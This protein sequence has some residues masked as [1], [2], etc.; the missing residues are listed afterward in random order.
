MMNN[1]RNNH[2][3]RSRA[4]SRSVG[5]LGLLLLALLLP[6]A[7]TAQTP[8]KRI[9]P[10]NPDAGTLQMIAQHV[11]TGCKPGVGNL[12]GEI[13]PLG[14]T[15]LG[16]HVWLLERVRCDTSIEE[17]GYPTQPK[18]F[19]LC[20]TDSTGVIPPIER[21]VRMVTSDVATELR[22]LCAADFD[23]NG[24]Q[25]VVCQVHRINDTSNGNVKGYRICAVAVFWANDLGEYAED[26]TTQISNGAQ[27]WL[28]PSYG[29]GGDI[30][31]DGCEDGL[32]MFT[33]SGYRD[34]K[35]YGGLPVAYLLRGATKRWKGSEQSIA[36]VQPWWYMAKGVDITTMSLLDADCDGWKDL[37]FYGGGTAGSISICYGRP[38]AF[39]DTNNIQTLTI[40]QE[41]GW[42]ALLSDVTGDGVPELL[43]KSR[44]SITDRILLFAG[45]PRQRL[46][47]QYGS[48]NDSLD[49]AQGRFPT[50]PWA[51]VILPS[52]LHDGWFKSSGV[53]NLGDVSGDG[54]DE[55]WTNSYPFLI[56]YVS[57]GKL[58]SLA[59]VVW[60]DNDPWEHLRLG[61][62]DPSGIAVFAAGYQGRVLYTKPVMVPET[63]GSEY[64]LPHEVGYRCQHATTAVASPATQDQHQWQLQV[65]PQPAH[66]HATI[67]WNTE[68]TADTLYLTIHDILGRQV[69]Q[70]TIPQGQSSI[71]WNTANLV[72]G[73][74]TITLANSQ[75][76]TTITTLIQQH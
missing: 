41:L 75:H 42:P 15:P 43:V 38:N 52:L 68:Q 16:E 63:W 20:R 25:D 22:F 59:D 29:I 21:L 64:R 71:E 31:N 58:D 76:A 45:K 13:H 19:L 40:P 34:G 62:L 39:P 61:T 5:L 35:P 49:R 26:D 66:G 28:G 4:P 56:G 44:V 72:G 12:T 32:L 67:H 48:G 57:G 47:E 2:R 11:L 1:R 7:A 8:P 6:T 10:R 27:A 33:G 73:V 9:D 74:Y 55:I 54:A 50:R 24:Y 53:F 46:L 14:K 36:R 30:D 60:R 17:Y 51:Q 18:D 69:W 3:Q 23:G 65:F 37:V 70:A